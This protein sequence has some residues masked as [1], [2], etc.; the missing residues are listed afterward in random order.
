MRLTHSDG[1]GWGRGK[2]EVTWN[3]GGHSWALWW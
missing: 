3:S 1:T 2:L